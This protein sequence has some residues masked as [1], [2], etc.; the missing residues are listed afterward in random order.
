MMYENE[1]SLLNAMEFPRTAYRGSAGCEDD[2]QKGRSWTFGIEKAR[3]F[4]EIWPRRS[5]NSVQP[6]LLQMQ[7]DRAEVMA[8]LCDR[9]EEEVILIDGQGTDRTRCVRSEEVD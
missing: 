9:E 8:Y 4:A 2:V 1:H 3:F 5:G 7:I 6:V